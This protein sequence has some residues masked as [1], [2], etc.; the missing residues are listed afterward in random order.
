MR[1]RKGKKTRSQTL[2]SFSE[3]WKENGDKAKGKSNL[4]KNV[5]KPGEVLDAQGF[6]T[7]GV[8]AAAQNLKDFLD[9]Q[10]GE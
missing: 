6:D 1:L 5:C 2:S 3:W 7:F 10:T 8:D 9:N 4:S